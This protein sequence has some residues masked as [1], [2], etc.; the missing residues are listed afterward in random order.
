MNVVYPMANDDLLQRFKKLLEENN[1]QLRQEVK[2]EVEPL[3]ERFDAQR[4]QINTV[5]KNLR[6]E[7]KESDNTVEKNLRL[8]IKESEK[9]ILEQVKPLANLLVDHDEQIAELQKAVGLRPKH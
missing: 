7:I 1:K 5:E 4:E 9:N 3:H 6:Q 2:A 8:D